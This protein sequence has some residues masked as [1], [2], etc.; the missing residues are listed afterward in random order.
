[1]AL[2]NNNIELIKAVAANDL[3]TAKRAAIASLAEDTS[4]KNAAV[5][6]YYKKLL[7][8]NSGVLMSNLPP[9][10]RTILVG[11]TPD[12]FD[13]SRY[14]LR[15]AERTVVD[16]IAK[17]KAVSEDMALRRIPYR[18]TT[19]LYGESGTGKTEL[20][21][22]IAY[23]LNL[24]FFYISFTSAIDSYMGSTA[25]N[26]S[27]VFSFC[28]SFPCVLMIDEVDCVA[29]RRE[30]AGTKG[31]DGE[32]ERTTISLMQE[33]DRLP[34]HVVLIAATNRADML[35]EALLRRFSIK[36][37]IKNMSRLE[38]EEL[39]QLFL[40]AT[41]TVKYIDRQ[42]LSELTE[43][44]RNPGQLMP[45]LIRLIGKAVYEEKKDE[46][47]EKEKEAEEKSGSNLWC[48]TYNWSIDIAADTKEDA[49][50]IGRK[51]RLC[52]RS[53]AEGMYTAERVRKI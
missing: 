26:I 52:G 6:E 34:N 42:I 20:G 11:E 39:A 23:K 17:M 40:S 49:I 48:V 30:A 50:A 12:G 37:E 43:K 16:D 35:D 53:A 15:A 29:S 44:Y 21:R 7:T 31:V 13:P 32:L 33:L 5:N 8:G 41:D 10:L 27:N 19:L 28:S 36:H 46:L 1:M 3:S 14:Y 38:L 24:P 25:K 18:N 22:Y 4:K 2:T 9:N 47:D 45:E 51:E